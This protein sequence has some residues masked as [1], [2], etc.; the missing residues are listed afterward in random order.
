M[1]TVLIIFPRK[2]PASDGAGWVEHLAPLECL[3]CER[4]WSFGWQQLRAPQKHLRIDRNNQGRSRGCAV[5]QRHSW[6]GFLLSGTSRSRKCPLRSSYRAQ[7]QHWRGRLAK[8]GVFEVPD[9][10]TAFMHHED[11]TIFAH[12]RTRAEPGQTPLINI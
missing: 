10:D 5:T 6:R 3:K 11:F 7:K 2:V 12:K 4:A 9:L 1:S 8:L